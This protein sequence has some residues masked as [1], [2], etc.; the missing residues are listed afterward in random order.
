[1]DVSSPPPLPPEPAAERQRSAL[2]SGWWLG[3]VGVLVGLLGL[4]T[5]FWALRDR[6]EMDAP[7]PVIQDKGPIP[8]SGDTASASATAAPGAAGG[9][10]KLLELDIPT[11]FPPPQLQSLSFADAFAQAAAYRGWQC[12]QPEVILF[13]DARQTL[14]AV[15]ERLLELGYQV[16]DTE[17]ALG[18]D[19]SWLAQ[20]GERPDLFVSFSSGEQGR[21][22]V[23][24]CALP[25]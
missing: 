8:S 11:G 23:S 3:L 2:P 7:V 1:M 25:R 16:K 19:R 14:P 6:P 13:S 17:T 20:H 5:A 21:G 4:G 12:Q 10:S 22:N 15:Q 18:E 24:L 9:H